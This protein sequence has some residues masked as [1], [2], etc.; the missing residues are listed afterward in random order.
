LFSPTS[1]ITRHIESDQCKGDLSP[2][3]FRELINYE[4]IPF[5]KKNLLVGILTSSSTHTWHAGILPGCFKAAI[6]ETSNRLKPEELTPKDFVSVLDCTLLDKP[7]CSPMEN[8]AVF[9]VRPP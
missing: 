8:P 9:S 6:A 1:D 5:S 7:T 3:S 4:N 2:S